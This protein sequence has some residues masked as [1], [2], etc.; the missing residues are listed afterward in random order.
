MKNKDYDKDFMTALLDYAHT[1]D[2]ISEYIEKDGTTGAALMVDIDD[3]QML[4]DLL[5][6]VFVL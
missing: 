2:Y 5:G 1:R 3:F 6:Y 4:N